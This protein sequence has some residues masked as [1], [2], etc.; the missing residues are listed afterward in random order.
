MDKSAKRGRVLASF[1][2]PMKVEIRRPEFEPLASLA[3]LDA[4]RLSRGN[5]KGRSRIHQFDNLV[6]DPDTG[7]SR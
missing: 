4:A 3:A 5:H 7:W 1:T 6:D 2:V